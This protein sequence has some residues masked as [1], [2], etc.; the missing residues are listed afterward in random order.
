MR[1]GKEEAGSFK[2]IKIFKMIINHYIGINDFFAATKNDLLPTQKI[3]MFIQPFQF[4]RKTLRKFHGGRNNEQ[5]IIFIK[6][7]QYFYTV[8]YYRR[9]SEKSF[10]MNI[11]IYMRES[12]SFFN[13][14]YIF[15]L[16]SFAKIFFIVTKK[17]LIHIG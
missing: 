5:F 7:H 12:F 1:L 6:L 8:F 4:F 13:T 15:Y 2:K 17:L 11:F 14:N 16:S 3:E 10:C 9:S